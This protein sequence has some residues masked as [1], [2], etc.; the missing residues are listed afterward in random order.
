MLQT[1][2]PGEYSAAAAPAAAGYGDEV[3]GFLNRSFSASR[4]M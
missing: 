1:L 2:A 4:S 3:G